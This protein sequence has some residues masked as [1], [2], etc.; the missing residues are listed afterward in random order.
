MSDLL[1]HANDLKRRISIVDAF[2]RMGEH[3]QGSEHAKW[4]R[5]TVMSSL[6]VNTNAQ[7]WSRY[8]FPDQH[9]DI[10]DLVM[11]AKGCTFSEAIEMVESGD[12]GRLRDLPALSL[13]PPVFIQPDLS[14]DL[15]LRYHANLDD[16]DRA[17]WQAQGIGPEAVSRFFL[18]SCPYHDIWRQPTMTIPVIVD[19]KLMDVRHRLL[20]P[21]K[22]GDKYRPERPGMTA[23]LFNAAILTP[24]QPGVIIVAGEK[25]VIVGWQY[26]LPMVSAT[27][28]CGYWD[29]TWTTRFQYCRKVYIAFDPG[30]G[31]AAEKLAQRIGERAWLVDLPEKPD[32]LLVRLEVE[33]GHAGAIKAFRVYLDKRHA[34]PYVN[35]EVWKQR[36]GGSSWGRMREL[37]R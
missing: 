37:P 2:E 4:R 27:A 20:H 15:H 9:G 22:T 3:F 33:Q 13:S 24:E 5:G 23:Q 16:R 12:F 6:V 14:Q 26:G 1:D 25:K 10:F 30:E 21:P 29:D 18:G 31:E 35:A 8:K 7:T 19:G 28:G 11:L 36:N 34:R 17:W 32:D